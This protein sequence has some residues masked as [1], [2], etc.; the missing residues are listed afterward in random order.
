MSSKG[1]STWHSQHLKAQKIRKGG[2]TEQQA[3]TIV[4]GKNIS[5]AGDHGQ[6]ET[7][8]EKCGETGICET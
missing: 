7:G 3:G 8:Q 1:F 2:E 4:Q 5:G 6:K